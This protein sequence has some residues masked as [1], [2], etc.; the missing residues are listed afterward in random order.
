MRASSTSPSGPP[1]GGSPS[2]SL[3]PPLPPGARSR[4][5]KMDA[6][7]HPRSWGHRLPP[8]HRRPGIRHRGPHAGMV[9]SRRLR[10][11]PGFHRCLRRRNRHLRRLRRHHPLRP[12]RRP[13]P[14]RPG[15]PNREPHRITTTTDTHSQ[16][17]SID[18]SSFR[19]TVG[20]DASGITLIT[21][22]DDQGPVG[23]TLRVP[24][25]SPPFPAQHC[26]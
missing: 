4:P 18:Q 8:Q 6:P 10:R 19:S 21:G 1:S 11:L 12:P 13:S 25:R 17:H 22:L 14:V 24:T 2:Q 16:S 5:R 20:R 15:R 9:R 23:L 26:T 7:R 3:R